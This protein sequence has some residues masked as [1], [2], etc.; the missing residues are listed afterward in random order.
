[1]SLTLTASAFGEIAANLVS[2]SAGKPSRS[3]APHRT[4]QPVLRN[5]KEEGTFEEA[6]WNILRN[7]TGDQLVAAVFAMID[8]A[9]DL[10][11]AERNGQTLS[12]RERA[13]A[14]VTPSVHRVI[15]ELVKLARNC[16]GKVYPS[17]KTIAEETRLC[18]ATVAQVLKVLRDLDILDWQRRFK[19][20]P[21]TGNRQ[22]SNAYRLF[23]PKLVE[24]FVPRWM[25]STPVS[26][27]I[28][29][30]Q[31]QQAAEVAEMLS[32][33]S[34]VEQLAYGGPQDSALRRELELL[35]VSMDERDSRK[36]TEPLSDSI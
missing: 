19:R 24:K 18:V 1:M 25:R 8:K 14:A 22:T 30:H 34:C 5:S 26:S 27:D 12:K 28:E 33:A 29:H 16:R 35:A 15:V 32:S 21:G 11:R 36:H 2:V 13:I 4:G 7:R 31:A 9:K 20:V 3:G 10:K 23:L 6:F 17:Y